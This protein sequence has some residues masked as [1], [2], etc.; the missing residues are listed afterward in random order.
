VYRL[1]EWQAWQG[2]LSGCRGAQVG[3]VSIAVG[4]AVALRLVTQR[5]APSRFG[6][7]RLKAMDRSF[8]P[9][10]LLFLPF[11][12]SSSRRRG[13]LLLLRRLE[14][15][16]AGGGSCGT[17]SGDEEQG[18]G[19]R[20]FVK[21]PLRVSVLQM[22]VAFVGDHGMWILSVGLPA[23]V[24]T[25]ERVATLEKL[26]WVFGVVLALV[27]CGPASP[28]YCLTLCWFRSHVGRSGVR[29]Q[30]GRTA[31]FVVGS[32][33]GLS[34][35]WRSEV[36]VPMGSVSF[37]VSAGV[38][39]GFASTL[40]FS[41]PTMV[42]GR[43]VALVASA[44]VDSA[45]FAGSSFASAMLEFLLLRLV[46]S[47]PAGSECELQESIAAVAGSACFEC[48]CWFARVAVGF[49]VS[50]RIFGVVARAKQMLM[51]RVALLVERCD[52]CLWLLPTVCWVVANSGPFR[53]CSVGCCATSGLRYAVVCWLVHSGGSS[54]NNALV[55]LVE[56][57]P[58]LVVLLPLS[59]VFSL[60][61]ICLGLHSGD[62][63]PERLLAL[64]VEVLPKLPCVVPLAVRLAV[65]LARLSSCSFQVF[66]AML[67]GLRV[68][69]WSGGCFI[70]RTLWALPDGSLEACC[71]PSSST[72]RG[73][74]GVVVLC[75][76]LGAVLRTMATAKVPPLLS[77]FEVDLVAPFV[78]FVSLWHDGLCVVTVLPIATAIQVVTGGRVAFLVAG[79]AGGP[80]RMLRCPGRARS[81]R[82]GGGCR[83]TVGNAMSRLVVFWEPQAK[84]LGRLSLPLLLDFPPLLLLL[85]E[86]ERSP[87]SSPAVGARRCRRRLVWSLEWRR[88]ERRWQPWLREGPFGGFGSSNGLLPLPGTPSPVRLLREF[89]GRRAC[90]SARSVGY[91]YGL[92][93]LWRSEVAVP[94]V[95]RCFSHGCSVSLVVTPGCSFL[96]SWRFGMLGA[97]VVRLWSHVVAP[98]FLASA[99]VDSTGSMGI[100]FIL[101]RSSFASALLEFLLLWLIRDCFSSD[102]AKTSMCSSKKACRRLMSSPIKVVSTFTARSKL[103]FDGV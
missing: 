18:G 27:R 33:C 76:G 68:S 11:S 83:V 75:H 48:G 52:T 49:V 23:D 14:L 71:V 96:T 34:T 65:V 82:G 20:G 61:A 101:T 13:L 1:S 97:C 47:F 15:G 29:L 102:N 37:F 38:C 19:G 95:R 10:F 26:V 36:A 77:C 87:P 64:W 84:I 94:V 9:S 25:A 40:C 81:G 90:S 91:A 60:L 69:L 32:A 72:F 46:V 62:V 6:S 51:C 73:L 55:V 24:A 54:Q 74:L 100:V 103:P 92:S 89:S 2:D 99:C 43:G 44:C 31:V 50:L 57:L 93:T 12:F 67:V 5:P 8:F 4:T 58:E 16:G 63:F 21:A 85:S 78:R 56:V 28:S 39:R 86:E 7:R 53:A 22:V 35:L 79:V 59:A 88:G 17:W 98:G 45:G 70:S 30:F 80:V 41:G 66:S 42:A 3:R